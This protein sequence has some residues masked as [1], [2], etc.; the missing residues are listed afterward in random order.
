MKVFAGRK[1]LKKEKKYKNIEALVKKEWPGKRIFRSL[2]FNYVVSFFKLIIFP[3]YSHSN[4]KDWERNFRRWSNSMILQ[5][6]W[7]CRSN[8]PAI[9]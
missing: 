6:S 7:M 9:S 4:Q 3:W 5:E 2:L 8:S 1:A